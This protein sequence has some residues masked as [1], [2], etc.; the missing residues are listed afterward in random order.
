MNILKLTFRN[1][2]NK[3]GRIRGVELKLCIHYYQL[4]LKSE[5]K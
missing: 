5:V 3:D 4:G 2:K 1:E